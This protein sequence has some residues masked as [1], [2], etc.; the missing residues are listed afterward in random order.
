MPHAL[1]GVR[2]RH[3]LRRGGKWANTT[4]HLTILVRI[5][6]GQYQCRDNATHKSIAAVVAVI[7]RLYRRRCT[8]IMCIYVD[9][10]VELVADVPLRV[11][12][13]L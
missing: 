13:S 11:F 3:G 10:A 9:T 7:G 2:A 1:R 12:T 4:Q 5:T 8:L 6:S